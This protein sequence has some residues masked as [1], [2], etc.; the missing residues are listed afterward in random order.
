M[1]NSIYI[2]IGIIGALIETAVHFSFYGIGIELGVVFIIGSALYCAGNKN[3]GTYVLL[4]GACILDLFSPYRFGLFLVSTAGVLICLETLF[5]RIIDPGNPLITFFMMVGI[6][7]F[8]HIFEFLGDPIV[9]V[10]IASACINA[11]IATL[12]TVVFIRIPTIYNSS[13]VVSKDVRLR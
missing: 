5:S 12:T 6:F 13:I 7:V 8:L 1:R 4:S 11:L 10:L 3:A 2:I 9:L